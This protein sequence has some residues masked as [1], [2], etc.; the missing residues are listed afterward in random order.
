MAIAQSK[1]TA[2]GQV[3]VPV[4]VRKRLG[5]GPG[6]GLEWHEQDGGVVVRRVGRLSSA[7]IHQ[8][9]FSKGAPK[10]MDAVDVKAAIRK[11]IKKRHAGC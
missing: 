9:L 4:E 11:Y 10:E 7:E 1:V 8:K 6:S 5:V 3:S 2:Q